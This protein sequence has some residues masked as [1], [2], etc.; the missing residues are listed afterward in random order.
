MDYNMSENERYS[1]KVLRD[2]I[3]LQ[4]KKGQDYQNKASTVKQADY[5]RLGLDTIYDILHA[6]MLRMRSQLEASRSDENHVT[7]FESISDSAKDMINY[8]SFFVSYADGKMDGQ[9][10][11]KDAFNRP[12]VKTAVD[13]IFDASDG[14]ATAFINLCDE[15]LFYPK[16]KQ[17]GALAAKD[18]PFFNKEIGLNTE[19]EKMLKEGVNTINNPNEF[20]PSDTERTIDDGLET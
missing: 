14:P 4:N 16:E 15:K 3:D 20:L 9:D 13:N 1:I 17:I 5:Y 18:T 11:T 6:K 12:K 19:L 8:L 10:L 7:N 2:C